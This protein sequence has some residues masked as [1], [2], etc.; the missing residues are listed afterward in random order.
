MK[1]TRKK[2][3][4]ELL[5]AFEEDEIDMARV[6]YTVFEDKG[7]QDAERGESQRPE[8]RQVRAPAASDVKLP[9]RPD[10]VI[11]LVIQKQ[12][13]RVLPVRMR[14][15]PSSPLISLYQFVHETQHFPVD[16]I[17]LIWRGL[18]CPSRKWEYRTDILST[19][20]RD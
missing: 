1:L 14:I 19:Y 9:R 13:K 11:N 17:R 15:D 18:L 12:G 5:E 16:Q 3:R 8:S 4:K 6:W 20:C 10:N 7:A 2:T